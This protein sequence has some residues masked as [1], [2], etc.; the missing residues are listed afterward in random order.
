V[1]ERIGVIEGEIFP[2]LV[3]L[4][5]PVARRQE[6]R[7]PFRDGARA[8]L[9]A[10]EFELKLTHDGQRVEAAL[11]LRLRM[12]SP[13]PVALNWVLPMAPT[14]AVASLALRAAGGQ[15]ERAGLCERREARRWFDLARRAHLA[16][17]LL[18]EDAP[19]VFS[20]EVASPGNARTLSLAM[21]YAFRAYGESDAELILRGDAAPAER[22]GEAATQPILRLGSGR[23]LDRVV[24]IVRDARMSLQEPQ[25]VGALGAG[26]CASLSRPDVYASCDRS[27]GA[28]AMFR[29]TLAGRRVRL[30]T[31]L[32]APRRGSAGATVTPPRAD[33]LGR[34]MAAYR[35]SDRS[36]A[37][38]RNL[39]GQVGK[40]GLEAGLATLWTSFVAVVGGDGPGGEM[41]FAAA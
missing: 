5:R 24:G 19:G 9:P 13:T 32:R 40:L 29:G 4:L 28:L 23:R 30:W 12:A 38:R 15:T 2:L 10:Q 27:D 3:S 22:L 6:A 31:E 33:E 16:G 1:D 25:P 18:G 36:E 39:A 14:T 35:R 26:G 20:L 37:E 7:D 11:S 21:R 41:V 8:S 34:L 17:A